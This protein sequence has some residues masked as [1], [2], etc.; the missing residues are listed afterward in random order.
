MRLRRP[1]GSRFGGVEPQAPHEG[2]LLDSARYLE[3]RGGKGLRFL[4]PKLV[5][6][7]RVP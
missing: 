7:L 2:E 1:K 3:D 5:N 6:L 4:T